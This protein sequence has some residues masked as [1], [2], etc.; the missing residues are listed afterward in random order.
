MEGCN[1]RK[2]LLIKGY[3]QKKE[4]GQ[5]SQNR[6]M[7]G[8]VLILISA[9]MTST[10]QLLW[11]LSESS[12]FILIFC[13]FAFYGLGAITMTLSF[14]HGEMSVLHPML[15]SSLIL[16]ILFGTVLLDEPITFGKIAGAIFI[17]AGLIFLAISG[18]KRGE[19]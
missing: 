16:S 3:I 17:I 10:G 9:I 18:R 12:D 6:L 2:A 11:K 7:I 5:P 13:G 14:R 8:V 4:H 19:K 1:R 15:G